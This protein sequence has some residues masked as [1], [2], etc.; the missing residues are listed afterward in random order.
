MKIL[1]GNLKREKKEVY[2]CERIAKKS[3][4]IRSFLGYYEIIMIIIYYYD[5]KMSK[6]CMYI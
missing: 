6:I 2:I 5:F 4:R 3:A 1:H